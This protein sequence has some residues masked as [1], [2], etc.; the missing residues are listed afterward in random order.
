MRVIRTDGVYW[1]R[2]QYDFLPPLRLHFHRR[3]SVLG[4]EAA[5]LA[6]D[7]AVLA[8]Q[9]DHRLRVRIFLHA[10]RHSVR[11]VS[12]HRLHRRARTLSLQH[13]IHGFPLLLLS[14]VRQLVRG[15]LVS[16]SLPKG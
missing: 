7:L 3:V 9:L 5:R 12:L 2:S 1:T 15:A 13:S 11:M 4:N 16:P 14:A 6:A 8:D 10:N